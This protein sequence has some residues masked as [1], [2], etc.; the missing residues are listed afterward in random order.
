M[1][2]RCGWFISFASG[3]LFLI[4]PYKKIACTNYSG[5]YKTLGNCQH[6]Y[7]YSTWPTAHCTIAF[8]LLAQ[9]GCITAHCMVNQAKYSHALLYNQYILQA[10]LVGYDVG[11]FSG[12]LDI[13]TYLASHFCGFSC[14]KG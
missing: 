8:Q 1:H 11:H 7:Q 2:W 14:S 5:N 12:F 6:S 3:I 10:A 9:P 13:F 4:A